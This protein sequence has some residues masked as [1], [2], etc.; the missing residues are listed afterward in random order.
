MVGEAQVGR[1]ALRRAF[2]RPAGT[3]LNGVLLDRYV[4]AQRVTKN[5]PREQEPYADM[6]HNARRNPR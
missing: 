4:T 5:E 1:S 6:I 2:F 3:P